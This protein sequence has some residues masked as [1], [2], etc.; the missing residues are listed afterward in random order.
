MSVK[1]ATQK[2]I[3]VP[4]DLQGKAKL[5][6]Q[7]RTFGIFVTTKQLSGFSD[8]VKSGFLDEVIPLNQAKQ[9]LSENC[10]VNHKDTYIGENESISIYWETEKGSHGWCCSVCGKVFQWG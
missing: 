7:G 6:P 1:T 3:N 2:D 9:M 4:K 8:V 5:C 10:T